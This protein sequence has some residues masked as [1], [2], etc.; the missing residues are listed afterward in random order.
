MILSH[1]GSSSS[2]GPT[3]CC[4]SPRE[5]RLG[6]SAATPSTPPARANWSRCPILHFS[7][8]WPALKMKTGLPVL[9]SVDAKSPWLFFS[10]FDFN[11]I[12]FDSNWV[13]LA[14]H[15]GLICAF[16]WLSFVCFFRFWN[17]HELT[18]TSR[19]DLQFHLSFLTNLHPLFLA[20]VPRIWNKEP[21]MILS[22]LFHISA[23]WTLSH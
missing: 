14:H 23:I 17:L 20:V 21:Y 10:N 12:T 16:I 8:I 4:S 1:Q 15:P 6:A 13:I 7:S 22:S 19:T 9:H 11:W 18:F 3:T 5:S 2:W